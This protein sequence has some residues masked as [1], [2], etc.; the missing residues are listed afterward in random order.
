MIWIRK[1]YKPPRGRPLGK[2]TPLSRRGE[3]LF[4]SKA[5]N[6]ML[7]RDVFW[8]FSDHE[9]RPAICVNPDPS[10]KTCC[11][12]NKPNKRT[13]NEIRTSSYRATSCL[14]PKTHPRRNAARALF[15]MCQPRPLIAAGLNFLCAWPARGP[16]GNCKRTRN[17]LQTIGGIAMGNSGVFKTYFK[18]I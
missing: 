15:P 13:N 8:L 10:S 6:A 12:W 16:R 2:I 4:W 18:H 14:C 11:A 17:R 5:P 1:K 3:W 9:S 7:R